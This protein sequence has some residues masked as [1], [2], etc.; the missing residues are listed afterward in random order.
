M[1]ALSHLLHSKNQDPL[2]VGAQQKTPLD[3]KTIFFLFTRLVKQ[4]YGERGRKAIYPFRYDEAVLTIKVAS[5]LWASE[6]LLV[7][8]ELC[9]SLNREIGTTVVTDIRVFHG[10]HGHED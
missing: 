8:E 10:L 9:A 3:A 1:R 5:P 6:L 7:K 4:Y 2:Q